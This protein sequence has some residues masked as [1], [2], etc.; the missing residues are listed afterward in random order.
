MT[1]AAPP[2][3][4]P[5]TPL[6]IALTRTQYA[7]ECGGVLLD[8]T[9]NE[10]CLLFYPDTSE[11]RL[12]IGRADSMSPHQS[13]VPSLDYQ[14]AEHSVAGCEPYAHTAQRQISAITGYRCTHLH[15]AVLAHAPA[16]PCAYMG[17]QMVEPLALQIELRSAP[18]VLP[19]AL[20]SAS[21]SSSGSGGGAYSNADQNNSEQC[22]A[23]VS[24]DN[25]P[26][27]LLLAT[28][29]GSAPPPQMANNSSSSGSPLRHLSASS[30]LQSEP[31]T[32]LHAQRPLATQYVM[33]YYYMAWLTQSR[34]EQ[35]AATLPPGPVTD[36]S[37]LSS[38]SSSTAANTADSPTGQPLAEVTWFKMDTAAQVLTHASDKVALREA[39]HRL[40]RSDTPQPPF[41]Y[42]SVVLSQTQSRRGAAKAGSPEAEPSKGQP[43]STASSSSTSTDGETKADA[44][45]SAVVRNV[46][47]PPASRNLDIIRKTATTLSKRGMLMKPK[48]RSP[49]QSAATQAKKQDSDDAPS[50]GAVRFLSVRG[51]SDS[52]KATAEAKDEGAEVGRKS[53]AVDPAGEEAKEVAH[54]KLP[55]PRVFSIFYKLVGTAAAA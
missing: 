15:P 24:E 14:A 32:M 25:R 42:S 46:V 38:L 16:N 3:S 17:P 7:L 11:W 8:P 43:A 40:S 55:L 54:K 31:D 39:I 10:V 27:Q 45:D 21:R 1:S 51:T 12:P 33:T 2:T 23:G 35:R 34:L 26:L 18:A 53:L 52:H 22:E 13:T 48:Q 28:A 5:H 47:S 19:G 36:P 9:T 49:S 37:A 29:G 44:N 50:A 41:A 4:M 30:N 6:S 20:P